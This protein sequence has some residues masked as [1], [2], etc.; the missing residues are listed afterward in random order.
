MVHLKSI[1]TVYFI[2]IGGIGMSALARYLK[3][4]LGLHVVGYDRIASPVTDALIAE[5]IAVNHDHEHLP[6]FI[7]SHAPESL[8]VVRTPAVPLDHPHHIALAQKGVPILKRSELLGAI[9]RETPA[10]AVAGTH[11]KTTT[12]AILAHLLD[13]CPGKC[14]AFLGGIAAGVESNLYLHPN[15][16]WTVVEADEFDRSFLHLHPQHAVITSM[17]PDHLDIYG[18]E[19]TFR[20]A[21][22]LFAHQVENGCLVH[23][24]VN[25]PDKETER[26][27]LASTRKE[28]EAWTYAAINPQVIEGVWIADVQLGDVW[29]D[30]VAFPMPGLHN[31]SNALAALAL[32][33]RA[34]APMEVCRQRLMTFQGVQR[35]FTYQIR[36]EAGVFID[37]Y[38]HHPSEL[39][40]AIQTAR[41]QHPGKAITGIFQPHLYSRTR[42]HMMGFAAEL[43][44]LDHVILLPIY[45]AREEAIEGI[46]SQRLFENIPNTTKHLIDSERIF[47][48]L[49]AHPPEVLMTMGAGDIDRYVAPLKQW[50]LEDLN[51]FKKTK[52]TTSP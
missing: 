6:V 15:A 10:L 32:A 7:A 5:G 48:C 12:T 37:D 28:A 14:N 16:A 26:Y 29:L 50:L 1:S 17:D 33:H 11:G 51:R 20:D 49:K 41:S 24:D 39:K 46:D 31:V 3:R 47:D 8:L 21:F 9:V 34:G 45:A 25:W 27:G 22:Q 30:A 19:Q 23:A 4:Q 52:T 13:G 42:D 44:L 35:R 40:A 36:E 43:S 2:G 38:A 18:D